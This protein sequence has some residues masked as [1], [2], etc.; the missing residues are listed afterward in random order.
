VRF[1]CLSEDMD[2]RRTGYSVPRAPPRRFPCGCPRGIPARVVPRFLAK[3]VSPLTDFGP[4]SETPLGAARLV[5]DRRRSD[6]SDGSGSSHEVSRPFSVRGSA[7]RLFVPVPPG[8]PSL[9]DVS[10]VL[11]GF[12]P[13]HPCGLVS[14]H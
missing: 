3:A 9:H 10:H 6:I 7:D 11:E 2:A 13:A 12:V 5:R 14:C 4:S 8:T 1:P